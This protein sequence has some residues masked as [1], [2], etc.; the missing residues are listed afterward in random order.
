M[1]F[2]SRND[3]IP[4]HPEVHILSLQNISGI[5]KTPD[6]SEE[7]LM[8]IDTDLPHNSRNI[9]SGPLFDLFGFSASFPDIV[10][11]FSP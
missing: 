10:T 2:K 6:S 8:F 1:V 11:H 5:L 9:S 4:D 7:W 3:N